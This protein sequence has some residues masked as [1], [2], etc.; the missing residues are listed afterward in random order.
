MP[1]ALNP[2]LLSKPLCTCS[3]INT[4]KGSP[5]RFSLYTHILLQQKSEGAKATPPPP[6][7]APVFLFLY[8]RLESLIQKRL[9]LNRQVLWMNEN[10]FLF[11]EVPLFSYEAQMKNDKMADSIRLIRNLLKELRILGNQASG[12]H[13]PV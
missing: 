10:L 8:I 7:P 2:E 4:C 11:L 3:R 9:L 5:I 6:P 13:L 12:G 1:S